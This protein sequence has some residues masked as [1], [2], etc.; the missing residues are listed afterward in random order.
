MPFISVVWVNRSLFELAG[1]AKVHM[2]P[3]RLFQNAH[4]PTNSTRDVYAHL[5][6]QA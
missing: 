5:V 2:A 4:D 3:L 1:A 6:T